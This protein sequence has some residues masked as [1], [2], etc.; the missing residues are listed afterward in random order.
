MSNQEK[1]NLKNL[2]KTLKKHKDAVLVI[3]DKCAPNSFKIDEHTKDNYNRKNMIKNPS[4]FWKWYKDNILACSTEISAEEKA[5]NEILE[6][7]VVKFV[8]NLTHTDNINNPLGVDL[9]GNKNQVRCMGCNTTSRLKDNVNCDCVNEVVKCKKCNGKIAPTITMFEE[10]YR[11]CDLEAIKE[12]IFIEE[13]DSI[14]LNTHVIIFIGVDFDED[15]IH[16]LMESYNAIKATM[17]SEEY[18]TVM[19]CDKDGLSIEYYQPEFATYEDIAGAISRLTA[20]IK[21]DE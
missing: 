1:P 16:E 10:K 7:G 20:K 19:V 12:N 15:Y 14:K 8:L 18:Y 21:G 9:R 13:E 2:I 11:Q 3:G 4:D 5:I 17:E 6:T